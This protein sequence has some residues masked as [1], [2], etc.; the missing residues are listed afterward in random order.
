MSDKDDTASKIAVGVIIFMFVLCFLMPACDSSSNKSTSTSSSTTS[1]SVSSSTSNSS[2]SSSSSG[3]SSSSDIS[4]YSSNSQRSSSY[5]D[6][7]WPTHSSQLCAVPEANRYYMAYNYIG[8]SHTVVGPVVRVY[9]AAQSKGM[10]IFVSM[11]VSKMPSDWVTF[12]IWAEDLD[13]GLEEMLHDVDHGNAWLE[14][15]GTIYLYENQLQI[16]TGH[17]Y[18]EYRWWTNVN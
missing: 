16:Q 3:K 2:S 13:D 6:E 15:T 10:P 7:R 9:Q 12:V 17:G 8:Q 4:S 18:I 14:I 5:D 11:G 1:S